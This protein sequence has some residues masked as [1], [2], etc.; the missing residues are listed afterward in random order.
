MI[1]CWIFVCLSLAA[2]AWGAFA[3]DGNDLTA[4][5]ALYGKIEQGVCDQ[6]EA[7]S[8]PDHY[9]FTYRAASE[10]KDRTV[11]LFVFECSRFAYN[12]SQVFFI[13]DDIGL[14]PLTFA[15]PHLELDYAPED[16]DHEHIKSIAVR[17]FTSTTE[18]INSS[19]DQQSQTITTFDKW[20]GAGDASSN[21]LWKFDKGEFVLLNFD[22]DASFDGVN[23]PTSV[24]V[25]GA[26]KQTVLITP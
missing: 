23:N 18:L 5:K 4:A 19:V 13:S 16:V 3:A 8:A 24:L 11:T 1:R 21:G 10:Q 25:D 7:P 12:T 22:V 9:V 20:R 2:S 17:G 14:R 6:V 26:I 15:V